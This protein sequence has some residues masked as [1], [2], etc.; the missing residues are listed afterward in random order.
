MKKR[1]VVIRCF[2]LLILV[3]TF[4]ACASTRTHESTG[5]HVDDSD[6]KI[7]ETK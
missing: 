4:P 6:I 2:V 1:N 5:N 7:I 3:A